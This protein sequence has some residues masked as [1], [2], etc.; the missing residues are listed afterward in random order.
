MQDL[1][2]EIQ[3]KRQEMNLAIRLLK[4][5]GQEKAKAE[6]TYRMELAKE[7]LRLRDDGMPVTI[8]NDIARGNENI[9]GLKQERDI[10]DVLYDS[11]LQR[12]YATKLELQILDNQYRMAMKGE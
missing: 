9:A 7:I 10:A 8:I 6:N 1:I 2:I 11:V 4:E 12:L 5:R 3:E